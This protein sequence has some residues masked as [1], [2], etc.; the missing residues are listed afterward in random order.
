MLARPESHVQ[1]E[2]IGELTGVLRDHAEQ[3]IFAPVLTRGSMF[4]AGADFN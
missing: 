2:L 3:R 4:C 1:P